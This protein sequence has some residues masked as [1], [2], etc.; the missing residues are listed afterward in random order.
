MFTNLCFTR[1]GASTGVVLSNILFSIV[2]GSVDTVVICFAGSPDELE[3]NHP[4]ESQ[5]IRAA[6]KEAWP[7]TI[8]RISKS[9]SVSAISP[10][11]PRPLAR[12]RSLE[13]IFF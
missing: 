10:G 4:A 8:D 5:D 2:T 13:K 12:R 6:W 7:G 1:I 11:E 9:N 3:E